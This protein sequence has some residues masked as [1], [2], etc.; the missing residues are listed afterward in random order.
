MKSC[1]NRESVAVET[2]SLGGGTFGNMLVGRMGDV[3]GSRATLCLTLL[4]DVVLFSLTAFSTG[5]SMLVAV[6]CMAG[7]SS[8]LVASLLY[9]LERA[10]GKLQTLEAINAY[11]ISVNMGYAVGGVVV[12]LGYNSMGW[13]GVNL[14]SA[15]VAVVAIALVLWSSTPSPGKG[16]V[17][18]EASG[19]MSGEKDVT[20]ARIRGGNAVAAEGQERGAG[21]MKSSQVAT[22]RG[23]ATVVSQGDGKNSASGEA[24][25]RAAF[26]SG[27]M[28]SHCYTAFGVGY[29]FMG[30]IVTFVLMAKQV[31]GWSANTIG[32][33]FLAIP[34]ANI[35]TMYYVIPPT[36]RTLGVHTL[37]TC[38]SFGSCA[39][40]AVFALPAVHE[41]PAG[42]M[43]MTFLLII[44]VVAVQV[45]NQMRIKIIADTYA[46]Q[47]MG[48]ITGAS[49]VCFAGG[50]TAAPIVCAVLYVK[51]PV[52]AMG[53][54]LLVMIMIPVVFMLA[55]QKLF[56]DPPPPSHREQEQARSERSAA[57]GRVDLGNNL[58]A[59][60]K[61]AGVSTAGMLGCDAVSKQSALAPQPA[62]VEELPD[63]ERGKSECY[64]E[65]H[66]NSFKTS[67]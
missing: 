36:V 12:G 67:G 49:R 27:A 48:S 14:F 63:E 9:I 10:S 15:S 55:G 51:S 2:E 18:G 54:M 50:Q 61:A 39:I 8:P 24:S 17:G 64:C 65:T 26:R 20:G 34:V 59:M 44:C 31:L 23:N 22:I 3:L 43:S 53:S 11:S 25:A 37:I 16:S 40:L 41:S 47:H 56:S 46:P 6:R 35:V 7:L 52:L 28:L 66:G 4:G 42:I 33:S 38:A 60:T 21:E 62:G 19:E 13:V 1:V 58:E 45:P 30:F 32:W 29:Q 57:R 5:P